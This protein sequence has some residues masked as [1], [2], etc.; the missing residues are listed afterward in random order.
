MAELNKPYGFMRLSMYRKFDAS[1]WVY[2][3]AIKMIKPHFAPILDQPFIEGDEIDGSVIKLAERFEVVV[4][5]TPDEV[6]AAMDDALSYHIGGYVGI[7][8]EDL[9]DAPGG[10]CV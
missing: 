2:A 10:A 6:V 5:E 8:A 4:A 3:P 7:K 9:D 1:V